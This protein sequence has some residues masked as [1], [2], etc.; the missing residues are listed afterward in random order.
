MAVSNV[1]IE[2]TAPFEDIHKKGDVK[3]FSLDIANIFV[4]ELKVAKLY[5]KKAVK[6][7]EVKDK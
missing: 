3:E 5:E 1:K 4:K 2:F 6:D 7:K